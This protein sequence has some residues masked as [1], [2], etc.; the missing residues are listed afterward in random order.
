[1]TFRPG[2][3]FKGHSR[4]LSYLPKSIEVVIPNKIQA[5]FYI[6]IGIE[7][8]LNEECGYSSKKLPFDTGKM[9]NSPTTISVESKHRFLDISR[10]LF[11]LFPEPTDR[12]RH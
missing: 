2:T 3:F 4:L 10:I 7:N 8:K 1:M 5:K 11:V 6:V 12:Q 9:N